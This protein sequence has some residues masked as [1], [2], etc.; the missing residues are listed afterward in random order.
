VSERFGA[1]SV[2]PG[3]AAGPDA[4]ASFRA[5]DLAEKSCICR[6]SCARCTSRRFSI[7]M[8]CHTLVSG[9][10]SVHRQ[11]RVPY[12]SW[13]RPEVRTHAIRALRQHVVGVALRE[14]HRPEH[15]VD[16]LARN[17]FVEQVAHRVDEDHRGRCERNGWL[18]RSGRRI[19]LAV[20]F[21]AVHGRS[22]TRRASAKRRVSGSA[23]QCAQ[24]GETFEH[25]VTGST[26]PA[27]IRSPCYRAHRPPAR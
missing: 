11:N 16:E 13:P 15:A 17:L 22:G 9:H 24:P 2:A 8:H 3:R 19:T 1:D 20:A 4:G 23:E 21:A 27:S 7:D 6:N 10:R 25:S 5:V 12:P 18:S 14:R 26:S